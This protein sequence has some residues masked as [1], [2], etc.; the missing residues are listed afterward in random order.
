MG[1]NNLLYSIIVGVIGLFVLTVLLGS[2]YT[3]DQTQR[4]VLLRNGAFVEVVQP[5][6]HFKWPWID[7]VA[8]I[9][10]QTHTYTWTKMESYSADQQ[11]ANL[12]VSV[13]L[14]VAADK[15]PDMY[16]RFRGDEKA[17]IDR[18]IAPHLNEKVKV[19][20]GQYT[21]ARA[22][23]ARGQLNADSAK[24][25]SEAIAYDPVFGIESV[26]IE[27]IAFSPDYIKSVEQRM[28]AE[29]EV[30]RYRQQLEREK[31]QAE[32]VV[33]QAKAK[34]DAVRAEAQANADAIRFRGQAESDAIQARGTGE[35]AAIQARGA[36]EATAIRAKN[37]ALGQNPHLVPL[38]QAERWDGK[39][40]I[41]MVPGGAVPM[42]GLGQR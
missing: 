28:Q 17:A 4:G 3:I 9:D 25:L 5:G 20:F 24:A 2:W 29:V 6:L 11:P 23:S 8:K 37:D 13:T 19:V 14:H 35:A 39:L 42:L 38:M 26:Q 31:V 10:M 36:A 1:G 7:T 16:A 27:D 15:V 40:P 30:Q 22:I 21:A 41:T 32:I 34:A 12:K 18:I 33:T